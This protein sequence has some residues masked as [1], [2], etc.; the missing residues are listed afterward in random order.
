MDEDNNFSY[1]R[2]DSKKEESGIITRTQQTKPRTSRRTSVCLTVTFVLVI[3]AFATCLAVF[4]G[5]CVFTPGC[6]GQAQS[7][8]LRT[9]LG[10]V[11][12]RV[13][14]VL[15]RNVNQFLGV[16]YAQPPLNQLRFRNPVAVRPW[17]T[18]LDASRFGPACP[19]PGWAGTDEDCL[20]LNIYVT[21]NDT[22]N[23]SGLKPVMIWIHG[24][25][26]VAGSGRGSD[27]T[28]L[29][30][31]GDVVVVTINYRLGML[32]WLSTLD[33]ASPGNYGLW[34]QKMA[35]HFVRDNIAAFGGDPNQ[36]TIFGESG[37]G[38][39]VGLLSLCPLNNGLFQ[40]AI[41]Q[42]GSA[43]NRRTIA[44]DPV[45]FAQRFAGNLGCLR[46]TQTGFDS[47][48]LV[49]CARQ[50]PV[51]D[52]LAASGAATSRDTVAWLLNIA[53]VIDGELIPTHV[54]NLL[55]PQYSN[56][57][58]FWNID[59]MVGTT[60]A[61]GNLL[62]GPLRPFQRALGFN[63]ANGIPTRV[64]CTN[65]T[66]ALARDY[67]RGSEQVS[68][69][70]CRQYSSRQGD[71]AQGRQAVDMYGDMMFVSAAVETLRLHVNG[72]GNQRRH[73]QYLFSHTPRSRG[74]P[75]NWFR[76]A[77]HGA[78]VNFVFGMFVA[79]Q[80]EARLSGAMIDGWS[81]FA[82]FGN[83]NDP[84][85]PNAFQWPEYDL[86]NRSYT[87]LDLVIS[88]QRDIYSQR[89]Q[90]WMDTIPNMDTEIIHATPIPQFLGGGS[91][92]TPWG[93]G[94]RRD[95][96]FGGVS[97]DRSYPTTGGS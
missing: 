91:F 74:T 78:E 2:F 14:T 73:F 48:Y 27:G 41:M 65:I 54:R 59:V 81:N 83:P 50:R 7:V 15:N 33:Q 20:Y 40:R 49:Q 95:T 46:R 92:A 84:Q 8:T 28:L 19:Q 76:G 24:G 43:L 51:A 38:Y 42:S 23:S 58:P 89:M 16:P 9:P 68:D 4:L 70:L 47:Q 96:T 86:V 13:R 37:G 17:S 94:I 5:L 62:L 87:D 52:I 82:K 63:L 34:D 75:Y 45:G 12:G 53:P 30:V 88:A 85:N 77:G 93:F 67:F 18:P 60:S 64:L 3:M 71:Q 97:Q 1:V 31:R 72:T 25:G 79:D 55:G 22:F 80:A 56:R 69:A 44:L 39:T 90:F 36:I 21:A 10:D 26:F 35:I 32:G 61:E 6:E 11:T 57:V 66:T 29:A